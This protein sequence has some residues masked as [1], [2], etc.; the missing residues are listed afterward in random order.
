[1]TVFLFLTEKS[2]KLRPIILFAFFL[3]VCYINLYISESEEIHIG[4]G[5]K[6][7]GNKHSS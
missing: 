1:M 4:K 5:K 7:K 2:T 6:A 3:Y